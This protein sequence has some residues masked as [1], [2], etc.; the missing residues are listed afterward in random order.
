[1]DKISKTG[2]GVHILQTAE[3]RIRQ[4]CLQLKDVHILEPRNREDL[5]QYSCQL[6]LDPS[7]VHRNLRLSEGN[8]VVTE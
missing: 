3:P 2:K 8:R 1:M 4:L 7:T 5:L 6:T